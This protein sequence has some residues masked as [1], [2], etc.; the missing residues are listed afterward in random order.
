MVNNILVIFWTFII[1]V[2]IGIIIGFVNTHV[3]S[4][5][6]IFST[7]V[8]SIL[9]TSIYFLFASKYIITKKKNNI[10]FIFSHLIL[11][12]ICLFNYF[13]NHHLV[14]IYF[15]FFYLISFYLFDYYYWI[16]FSLMIF[17]S[18]TPLIY[19][20]V[21]I[22]LYS[23]FAYKN[24]YSFSVFAKFSILFSIIWLQIV[25]FSPFLLK[26]N[27]SK[28]YKKILLFLIGLIFL[29]LLTIPYPY[30]NDYPIP[31]LFYQSFDGKS[32]NCSFVTTFNPFF[33]VH[34]YLKNNKES[35]L[36]DKNIGLHLLL[37][38][39]HSK[40]KGITKIYNV[41]SSD[42]QIDWPKFSFQ[43]INKTNNMRLFQFQLE[44]CPKLFATSFEFFGKNEFSVLNILPSH[45][46]LKENILLP[47]DIEKVTFYFEFPIK[48]HQMNDFFSELPEFI[49]PEILETVIL[50]NITYL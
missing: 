14:F 20:F 17:S 19:V 50:M 35:Y 47:K 10:Y 36:I 22:R 28:T 23:T 33:T 12:I 27:D 15:G 1:L 21:Y 31:G 8:F 24:S 16:S 6:F 32:S 44:P 3:L 11:L 13:S 49:I 26:E 25:F 30:S 37:R 4:N 48:T 46:S 38:S 39:S 29:I 34:K 41:S 2:I 7:V 18:L 5:Y 43:E 40:Y 9:V 42:F 45:F